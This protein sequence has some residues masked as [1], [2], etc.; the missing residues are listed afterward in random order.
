MQ[1]RLLS[2]AAVLLVAGAVLPRAA[3]AHALLRH[4]DPPAGSKQPI[5]PPVVTLTF[6]EGVETRFSTIAVTDSRGQRMDFDTPQHVGDD[7]TTLSVPLHTLSPGTY[8]VTW[9]ATSVDTHKTQGS[10]SFQ[11]GG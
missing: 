3:H 11:V 7:P 4:A 1:R 6:S 2:A 10:Y 8:T 9:H 5:P